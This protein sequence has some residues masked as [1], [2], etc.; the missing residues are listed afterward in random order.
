MSTA[1]ALPRSTYLFDNPKEDVR[2]NQLGLNEWKFFKRGGES[3]SAGAWSEVLRQ[4]GIANI[5]VWHVDIAFKTSSLLGEF[6]SLA[7]KWRSE[8]AFH[9]SLGE[10]FTNDSYQKIIEKG[11]AVLPLILSELQKKPGHW[12]YALKEIVGYDVAEG[13]ENFVE[14]RKAWLTW[15][16]K[17]GHIQ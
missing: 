15:G 2:V 11:Y 8:T 7:N 14:A 1:L 9:S 5:L 6:E 4:G 3:I 10:I 13:A 12:F 17:N 16:Y